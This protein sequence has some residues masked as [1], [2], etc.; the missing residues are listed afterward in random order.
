MPPAAAANS[1]GQSDTGFIECLMCF[2]TILKD[3]PCTSSETTVRVLD[4]G[5]HIE[6]VPDLKWREGRVHL[7]GRVNGGREGEGV[8]GGAEDQ[9]EGTGPPHGGVTTDTKLIFLDRRPG[10][11]RLR[12]DPRL[13]MHVS[14]TR[15]G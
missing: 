11:S 13:H 1:S 9:Q 14:H 12:N 4:H 2:L 7:D 15:V 8:E 5:V 6:A 10:H 3:E